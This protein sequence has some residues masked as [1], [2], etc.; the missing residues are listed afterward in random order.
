MRTL[1]LLLALLF[2]A[3]GVF[4]HGSQSP[5]V[6]NITLRLELLQRVE[7][8]RAV[9]N[10]MISKGLDRL[11]D[12]ERTRWLAI[13]ADNTARMKVIIQQYGWP[14][15]ELV[16]RDGSEAALL[17]VQHA[18]YALQKEALPLVKNAYLAG[19]LQ[20]QDFALT[21]ARS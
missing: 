3:G 21:T 5:A 10:E 15:P 9:R 11:T 7:R 18:D 1:R 19:A 4:A 16:G 8:D 13:D 12:D 20:G 2:V 6:A 17:L 14:S